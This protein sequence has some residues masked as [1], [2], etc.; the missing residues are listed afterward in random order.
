MS[1]GPT[2]TVR[3]LRS[4]LVAA[5]TACSAGIAHV[6]GGAH[7]APVGLLV[8]LAAVGTPI[9]FTLSRR[10]WS[11]AQIVVVMGLAQVLL[12]AVMTM[13]MPAG[14]HV[15]PQLVEA[16]EGWTQMAAA[17]I[18]AT[19]LFSLCLAYGE[20]ALA[21]TL[22]GVLP[23]LVVPAWGQFVVR[24]T[25]FDAVRVPRPTFVRSPRAS[26]APPAVFVLSH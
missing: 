20:R 2:T 17:H 14:H 23:H 13:S 7:E 12:H 25:A 24:H 1:L 5:L 19:V 18:V 16:D 10:R 22:R 26:R 8:L 3:L 11:F 21:W 4:L 9:M 6:V 15:Q